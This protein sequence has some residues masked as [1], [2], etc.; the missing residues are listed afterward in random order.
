MGDTR[1]ID[2]SALNTLSVAVDQ[3]SDAAHTVRG[4]VSGVRSKADT[5]D[6]NIATV[7]SEFQA[8]LEY[9]EQQKEL[10]KAKTQ[11]VNVRQQVQE[12]F[13]VNDTVRQ[14][15]TGILEA[16]DLTI[17]RQ[18]VI[19]NCT[20]KLMLS[21]PEYWLAPCLVA[22]SAWLGDDRALADRALQEAIK[23][24]DEK[25][26][27]LFALVCR[28][29]GRMQASAVWLERYLAIQ[30]PH[31][32]ERKMVTVLD[33]YSN[34]LFGAQSKE[35]CAQKIRAW[36]EELSNEDGFIEAQ[37][38]NWEES[39]LSKTEANSF[40]SLYPC[41]AKYGTNWSDCARSLNETGLHQ[42]LLDYFKDIFERPAGTNASLNSRL[43][44]LLETY[45]SS[46]DAA[47]LPLRREER[48]LEL[49]IEEKGRRSRAEARYAAEQKALEEVLDFTTLLTS[50]A[51][52]ADVI[53]ASNATQR[54]AVA[55]SRD[56]VVAAYNNV[57]LRI[58]QHIPERLTID[59]E[60]WRDQVVDGSEEAPLCS[61]AEQHF[62]NRRDEE[63][64]AVKQ[65][66][67]DIA[68]PI[69]FAVV[70]IIA[71]ISSGATWGIMALLGAG[72]LVLRW[73]LNKKNC[74]KRREDIRTRYARIIKDVKDTVRAICA[75]RVDYI[76]DIRSRDA[77]SRQMSAYLDGIQVG[78]YVN[79]GKQRTVGL[80]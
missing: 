24:D 78:Q 27:L 63:I 40:A 66:K 10:A 58:R 12:K 8:Y 41:T 46:Y 68:L 1:I 14:Y 55:L 77:V 32:I 2:Q 34:G 51:M 57:V 31:R 42:V 29:F 47:E 54:L 44:E 26:C 65:S 73:F 79:T 6:K 62:T 60:G 75:E 9:D 43:D 30:D 76:S 52:H 15:L 22:L 33:A 19:A 49:I 5:L 56:W 61:K 59:I 45:I 13:G 3:L 64:A 69:I 48:L 70:A 4:V 53:K 17:V 23:R 16:T 71:F 28:R 20:E 74:E 72:G 38:K 35:I 25:T 36:I 50:A 11:I 21:C 37:Q 7:R 39:M 18:E 80:N 67:M